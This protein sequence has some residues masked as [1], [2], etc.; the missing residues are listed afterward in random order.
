ML[1]PNRKSQSI[2]EPASV[3]QDRAPPIS[4]PGKPLRCV[5]F[6]PTCPHFQP[7]QQ[8]IMAPRSPPCTALRFLVARTLDPGSLALQWLYIGQSWLISLRETFTAILRTCKHSRPLGHHLSVI[9]TTK[10]RQ[11]VVA[12]PLCQPLDVLLAIAHDLEALF[13]P[14]NKLRG[15]G[16]TLQR[17]PATAPTCSL[18]PPSLPP[19]PNLF[20]AYHLALVGANR[21]HHLLSPSLHILPCTLPSPVGSWRPAR[22]PYDCL[23][24]TVLTRVIKLQRLLPHAVPRR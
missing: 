16:H 17:A 8:P 14:T 19:P 20:V 10:K 18:L 21:H 5:R 24:I 6:S 1:H 15:S 7:P 12:C 11:C 13:Y 4:G 9:T 2:P 3:H 23:P 22:L